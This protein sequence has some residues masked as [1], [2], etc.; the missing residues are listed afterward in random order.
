MGRDDDEVTLY[1]DCK[2]LYGTVMLRSFT[3]D[4]DSEDVVQNFLIFADYRIIALLFIT[5]SC[6]RHIF[7]SQSFLSKMM[8][9]NLCLSQW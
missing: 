1:S 3:W 6:S 9:F 7:Q 5:L 2:R 8:C 4:M